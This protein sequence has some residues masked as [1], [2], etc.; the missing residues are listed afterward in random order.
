MSDRKTILENI[1]KL[2]D[3]GDIVKCHIEQHYLRHKDINNAQMCK[4][5]D[6][7]IYCFEITYS[8]LLRDDMYIMK[9]NQWQTAGKSQCYKDII[10]KL[11]NENCILSQLKNSITCV[12]YMKY[13]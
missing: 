10:E 8:L 4:D 5:C 9:T 11:F 1:K 13:S 7:H 12:D 2:V 3:N 6:K